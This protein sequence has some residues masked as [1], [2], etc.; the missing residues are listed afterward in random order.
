LGGFAARREMQS[1]AMIPTK[2]G[3]RLEARGGAHDDLVLAAASAVFAARL[4]VCFWGRLGDD[5]SPSKQTSDLS[6]G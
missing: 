3:I 2:R 6:G 5:T 4:G 1:F